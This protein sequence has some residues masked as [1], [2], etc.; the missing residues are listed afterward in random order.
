MKDQERLVDGS[1]ARWRYPVER[2]L[3]NAPILRDGTYSTVL[4]LDCDRDQVDRRI[5]ELAAVIFLEFDV[6]YCQA[7]SSKLNF[8]GSL[9]VRAV[10]R[11]AIRGKQRF[12]RAIR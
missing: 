9:T 2:P 12:S 11:G 5:D 8:S 10:L 7:T 4:T 1:I 3:W 6:A